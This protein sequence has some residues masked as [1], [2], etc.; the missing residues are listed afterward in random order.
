MT[1]SLILVDLLHNTSGE[2]TIAA[3]GMW[4]ICNTASKQVSLSDDGY[5]RDSQE[6][7]SEHV[8]LLCN[9]GQQLCATFKKGSYI[10]EGY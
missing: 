10:Y 5:E 1:S 2:P 9:K 6:G 4:T 7:R 8:H 3:G